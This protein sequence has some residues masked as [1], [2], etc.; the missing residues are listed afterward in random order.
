MIQYN[1]NYNKL[2]V[3]SKIYITGNIDVVSQICL[4]SQAYAFSSVIILE[5]PI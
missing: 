4:L 5:R 3:T 2:R 1:R